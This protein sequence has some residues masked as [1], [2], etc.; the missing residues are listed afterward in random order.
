MPTAKVRGESTHSEGQGSAKKGKKADDA[1][2]KN[3]TRP[4]RYKLNEVKPA[5]FEAPKAPVLN[6]VVQHKDIQFYE[7]TEQ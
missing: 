4:M 6:P 3:V 5:F 2:K 7:T 1:S